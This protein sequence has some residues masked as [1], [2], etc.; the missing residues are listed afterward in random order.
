[1]VA[2]KSGLK[3]SAITL[4]LLSLT[5]V[6]SCSFLSGGSD[7]DLKSETLRINYLSS[8]W[9]PITSDT[10]DYAAQNPVSN[11][12]ITANS[13]CKK[14]DSTSLKHLTSNI[15][16]GVEDP[17]TLESKT[18]TYS[19]RDALATTIKGKLDGVLTYMKIMTVRK[20][21]CVYD[22]I[23]ISPSF[24]AFDKDKNDF[25]DFLGQ[26]EID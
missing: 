15:L 18:L 3:R 14:Y 6:S 12:I 7:I 23:L 24:A 13:M 4:L 21:R 19:G 8:R 10:A 20:N 11:S 25:A 2:M 17:E 9:R 26:I 16:S 5:F 22:F 1:M